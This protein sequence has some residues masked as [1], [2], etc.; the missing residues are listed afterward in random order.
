MTPG[1]AV[2]HPIG[3][4]TY[5]QSQGLVAVDIPDTV[6]N[7]PGPRSI[8]KV[9]SGAK[10]TGPDTGLETR[11]QHEG[12]QQKGLFFYCVGLKSIQETGQRQRSRLTLLWHCCNW[13]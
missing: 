11:L 6:S 8:H 3:L 4:E 10:E 1:Q 13:S 9:Q 12:I 2:L 7:E 5:G